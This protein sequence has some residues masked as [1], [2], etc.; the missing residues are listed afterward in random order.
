MGRDIELQGVR[1]RQQDE[2]QRKTAKLK[3]CKHCEMEG[4]KRRIKRC[5]VMPT[6]KVWIDGRDNDES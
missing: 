3:E 6:A 1:E 4:K 5:R 2:E